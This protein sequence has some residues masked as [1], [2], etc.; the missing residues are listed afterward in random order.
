MKEYTETVRAGSSWFCPSSPLSLEI[1]KQSFI[2]C[3]EWMELMVPP[4]PKHT[5]KGKFDCIG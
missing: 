3:T 2:H 4:P 1:Q 5:S